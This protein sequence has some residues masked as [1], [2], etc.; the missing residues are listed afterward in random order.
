L[1]GIDALVA[2]QT[3]G[4]VTEAATRLRLTQ[5][6]VSKRIQALQNEV[7]FRLV[8]A[9][10]RRVRLTS[11]ATDFLSRARPL[12]AELRALTRHA[13]PEG[14]PRFSL[15]LADSVAAS[16]G[17]A[18]V[19]AAQRSLPGLALE[20]HAHRSVLVVE[21]VRLGRYDIGLCT[22]PPPTP[23]LV[24]HE[25]V[26]EPMVMVSAGGAPRGRRGG[27]DARRPLLTIESSS[28][29]WR[30]VLPALREHHPRLFLRPIVQVESFGAVVQMA[31]A[32]FG[33]GLVP[34]GLAVDLRVPRAERRELAGVARRLVLLTRK[35]VQSSPSFAALH[36]ELARAARAHV[37]RAERGDR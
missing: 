11:R 20:L 30:G 33:D 24:E 35:T 26:S 19:A 7:G 32:G 28:A 25:L 34:L 15:A 1:E 14:A 4:T 31:R 3:F 8:E 10:G 17:A 29:T 16:W 2:L 22:A 21:S 27:R 12:V 23:D 6:A 5:S 13:G 9:D 37:A 18:V 36:A